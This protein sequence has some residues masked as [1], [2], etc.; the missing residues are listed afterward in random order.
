MRT[1]ACFLVT[2][3][4]N[5]AEIV[6]KTCFEKRPTSYGDSETR[7]PKFLQKKKGKIYTWEQ[8]VFSVFFEFFSRSL[9]L[10]SREELFGFFEEFRGSGFRIPVAGRAFLKTCSD[11]I[12]KGFYRNLTGIFPNKLPGDFLN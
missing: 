10:G 6:Q 2:Q 8:N 1:S 3:I 9:G 11:D 5:P 12:K 7:A 4:R